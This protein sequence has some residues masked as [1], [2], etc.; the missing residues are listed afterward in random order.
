MFYASLRPLKHLFRSPYQFYSN[1]LSFWASMVNSVSG[2]GATP[3]YRVQ[4][5]LERIAI[6]PNDSH[7]KAGE[8]RSRRGEEERRRKAKA[9]RGDTHA[10]QPRA[11]RAHHILLL[12]VR[13][14]ARR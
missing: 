13:A 14:I 2:G 1:D 9:R 4:R 6:W 10:A 3:T 11:Q 12:H 8:Q 5:L 7:A